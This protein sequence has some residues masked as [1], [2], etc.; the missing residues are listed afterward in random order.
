MALLGTQLVLTLIMVSFIQKLG[1]HLSL[2]KWL[3]CS[4]GLIHYLHPTNEE[5]RSL[6]GIQKNNKNN[7]KN[8]YGKDNEQQVLD[9]FHVPRDLDIQLKKSKVVPLDVMH[10]RFY[11]EYQW[12]IDFSVY[13]VVIYTLTETYQLIFQAQDEVNLSMLWCFLVVG[14]AMKVLLSL[15]GQY[16]QSEDSG[17]RSTVI[18]TGFVYFVLAMIILIIDENSLELG[19][20]T[21][22]KVF[23]KNAI[24]FLERQGIDSSGPASKIVLK[25]FLALWCGIIGALFTFPG[26]R[27]ARMHW[28]ALNYCTDKKALKILLN[29][30]FAMPFFITI[31]WI[32]PISRDYLTNRIFHG[33]SHPLMSST[34][35]ESLRLVIVLL[36]VTL[37]FCFMPLYL[38]C[39][40]NMANS[41]IERIKK[42]AGRI[43]N[44]D[45]QK[46]I[47]AVFYYLC[48]VA[49]QYTAPI[50][51]CLFLTF[52]YKTLGG[53][54]W[55]GDILKSEYECPSDTYKSAKE[56][57]FLY[58]NFSIKASAHQFTLALESLKQVFT[59]EVFRG[60]FGLTT[61][62]TYFAWFAT[63]SV[64]MV[65]QSY[66]THI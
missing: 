55:T 24:A 54:T 63:T 52:M 8:R 35:F 14:F 9:T 1:H 29:V 26:L 4:T 15:T 53:F 48:V 21:A 43:T 62:W 36:A 3:L 30:N 13:A 49:L 58:D 32:K 38:Q 42:E 28:D 59:V 44:T 46:R 18:V 20:E 56:N 10:L 60:L 66:F 45:L 39:Y 12:L 50:L 27:M 57:K 34:S 40:L 25:F 5:L 65:Y 47:A 22:Y 7:K 17:E 19:L 64:G 11:S 33:M 31:L 6:A 16:F 23:N 41:R 2:G 51:I 37:H 61:W